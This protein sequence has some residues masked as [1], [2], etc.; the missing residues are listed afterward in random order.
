MPLDTAAAVAKLRSLTVKFDNKVKATTP[1]YPTIC[2]IVNSDGADEEYGMLGSVPA[3]REWLG[4]RQFNSVRAAKFTIENRPWESSI[5]VLKD[6]ID[7]DRLGLY[8]PLYENLAT[9][10]ARH[11]DKLILGELLTN[12]ETSVCLD[13]QFFYDTDHQWGSS[14]AQS[15]LISTAIAA[16]ATPTINEFKDA[17][18]AAVQAMLKYKDDQGEFIHDDAVYGLDSGMQLV[19]LVPLHYLDVANRATTYGIMVNNGETNV[20]A[21]VAQI[22]STPRITGN[23]FDLLRVD[24]P[25]RPF[26]FQE[27]EPLSRRLK[28]MDD[29]EFRDVKFMTK[30][31]YNAGY[32]AW[33]NAV[34]TKFTT[35]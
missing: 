31:R 30:A 14:G 20:P 26:I 16:A 19:A 12:A 28:G 7:D 15:N 34:R 4:D 17:L 11:P 18:S 29:I 5:S 35:A 9:R 2:T 3:V 24:T 13:G 25:V 1:F 10:A 21:V 33:W 8:T 27:R 22:V 32:G 23:Q 6:H